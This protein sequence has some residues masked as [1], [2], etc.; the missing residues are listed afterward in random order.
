MKPLVLVL[1]VAALAAC[2]GSTSDLPPTALSQS[3]TTAEDTAVTIDVAAHDPEDQPLTITA[4]APS[5]GTLTLAGTIYT[6]QPE[7]NFHGT[8]SAM[9]TV[10]DGHAMLSVAVT[11]TVTSVNDAPVAG[12]DTAAAALNLPATI[13]DSA[14]L[15]NDADVDGDTLTVVR[16]GGGTHGTAA[17][18]SGTITF[19]PETNFTGDAAFTYTISDG[20]AEAT[21]TVTVAVGGNNQAPVAVDDGRTTAEDTALVATAASLIANDT[22]A[23]GQALSM[24]AV[25]NPQNGTVALANGSVT[26][27]P[28]ANFAGLG[29]FDYTV[30]DGALTDTGHVTVTVTAVADAPIATDD[31]ATTAED[32]AVTV[33]AAALLA[34]DSDVDSGTLA[35]TAV[36]AATGGTV[37][38]VGTDLTFTPTANFVGAAGFDYTVSDG[39]LTDT[40][41]VVVTV[42]A[43]NDPPVA[44][45]DMVTTAEDT[46]LTITG[47]TLTGN[48]TDVD[49]ALAV[50]AVGNATSGTVALAGGNVTFTPAANFVGTAGFDYTVS[51]GALTDTAHVM[52]IVTAV[53]DP[54]VAVNDAAT[55]NEDTALTI[56][57]T[58]LVANDTDLDSGAL[59]VTAVGNATSGTVGLAGS[60][61]TFTPTANFHGVAGF[62]YT[63]SDGTLTDTGHVTVTVVSVNDPPV[64]ADDTGTTNQD[65][66]VTFA[67]AA[68]LAGDT[69]VDGDTLTIAAVGGAT[70]GTVSRAAGITT[71]TPAAGY[72]GLATFTYTVSDGALTDTGLVTITVGNLNDPPVAV[73]DSAATNEDTGLMLGAAT[74]TGNDTDADNDPLT[75]TAVQNPVNAVVTLAAGTITVTPSL[76]FHGTAS[77]E[78]VV[79]DGALTDIGLVTIAVA[80]VDDLPVA[81][82]DSATTAED[83]A[84]TTAV[85]A[86]DT[87]K[88]DGGLVVTITAPPA[89]GAAV[90]NGDN[91]VTFTPAANYAGGDAYTYQV[92]DA[93]GDVATAV[94]SVT[95]TP[96]NDPPVIAGSSVTAP[97]NGTLTINLTA[98]D[99]D[100]AGVTFAITTAPT[101]GAL[102]AIT[103]TGAFTAT[104]VYT[105]TMNYL[106]PDALAFT[107]SDG[108]LTTAPA[109]IAITVA[110]TAI[111]N[112]GVIGFPEECD[113]QNNVSGDGCSATCVKEAGWTCTGAP[114][115]CD[116]ICGD[117]LVVGSETCDDNNADETDGCTT[118]CQKG[119]ICT[120][121]AIAGGDAFA[122]DPAT[123]TCYVAFN[124][125][126][127]TWADAETACMALQGHLVTITSAAE[128]T[129]VQGIHTGTPWIGAVDDANDTDAV[130]DWVTTDA[131]GYTHFA[132][133]EPDDD[134]GLGGNGECLAMVNPA[135]E[136]GDTNCTFVGFTDGRICELEGQPCGDGLVEAGEQC[137][138]S[139]HTTGDGCSATC[140][141]EVGA[142]CTGTAPST[143]GKL[144]INEVDYDQVGAENS[145]GFFEFVEILNV[146]TAPVDVSGVNLVLVNGGTTTPSEY[147]FDGTNGTANVGKRIAL[148]SASVPSNLLPVG[149][150]IVVAP[151]A[152]F[153]VAG[154]PAAAYKITVV[155]PTAGWIQNGPPDAVALVTLGATPVVID[156]FSYEGTTPPAQLVG[157]TGLLPVSEGAGHPTGDPALVANV[158]M[159]RFPNGKDLGN[160]ATDWALRTVSPGTAN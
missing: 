13:T 50:T 106:G 151:A 141:V 129:R 23:D 38:L 2:G 101:H 152:Q 52:V 46:A 124:A 104:V 146:G 137:D 127:T 144:V 56:A 92:A 11:I 71:F 72:N 121:V 1:T 75:I 94:V 131:W 157:V 95:V 22:D 148:T 105:P 82:A 118:Q 6:Y 119:P 47:A 66:A 49:S 83:T 64:A 135:G 96:V 130:F 132:P 90:V 108:A 116:E 40:G 153:A 91:T 122:V 117:L 60:T 73:D 85:L 21:G 99:L 77:F 136:W 76:D 103:P 78:Y 15:A 7:A 102:G 16:V 158:G 44:V 31:A 61:V 84:V 57:A 140:Q 35:I 143:C 32:T 111:C 100:S 145:G 70:H 86:N 18:A 58:T 9:V 53:D 147:F 5:H 160:N 98:T 45:A 63:V 42:T 107:A 114:S 39:A 36:G 88:G 128:Q 54:P 59:T 17:L 150:I 93:D 97:A 65:A 14:L 51:D 126:A 48:D 79:S 4:S 62:D 110:S 25:A 26:F 12:P 120:A 34:N 142:T 81:N 154:F 69:D 139:N 80:S 37:A 87:G 115:A 125:D 109:T 20:V 123:G 112:D 24:T 156:A 155:P 19:T 74:L 67:D 29:G 3:V 27:T 134:A 41:H 138:D 43:V 30:T 55:T 159:S 89:H 113:D 8:D 133:G 149:G 68:L 10:S 33:T 28:A